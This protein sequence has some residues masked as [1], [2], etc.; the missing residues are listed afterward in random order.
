MNIQPLGSISISLRDLSL[1]YN[2]NNFSDRWE[3][4]NCLFYVLLF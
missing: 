1:P 2:I 3:I 4:G